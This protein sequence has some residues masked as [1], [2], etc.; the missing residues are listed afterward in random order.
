MF[1]QQWFQDNAMRKRQELLYE[2]DRGEMGGGQWEK[3]EGVNPT[4][5]NMQGIPKALFIHIF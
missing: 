2:S 5:N 4:V 1:S 3:I